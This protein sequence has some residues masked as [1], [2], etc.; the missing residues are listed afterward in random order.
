MF[1]FVTP[2]TLFHTQ[3]LE[4]QRTLPQVLDGHAAGIHDARIATRR[5]RELLP[6]VA[7]ERH[8]GA[9]DDLHA[10]FKR[11][12]RS[13]G[14]VRDAD[15]RVSLLASLERRIPHAAPT[16]V[17]VRQHRD[18][19]RLTLVRKLI[20]K[21]EHLEAFR[22]VD[23]LAAHRPNGLDALFAPARARKWRRDLQQ[24]VTARAKAANT[25]V[26]DATGVYF[27][28]RVHSARIA[29]KKLR[30]ALEIL[31]AVGQT[32]L[33][34]AIRELKKAQDTLGDLH[35]RQDLSDSL[36]DDASQANG[37]VAD[38]SGQVALVRQVLDAEVRHLHCRY[39]ERRNSI[40]TICDDMARRTTL[41]P[42]PFSR[43]VLALGALALSSGV[44]LARRSRLG[45]RRVA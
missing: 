33:S 21:L 28:N 20:K 13:L 18:H 42:V 16:L 11:V 23:S 36:A 4:L 24:L 8:V 3:L 34:A 29:I 10:R 32:D 40:V 7:E 27:P 19:E 35:D 25:A 15:V 17:V 6:L 41:A 9:T 1:D 43:P 38:S 5:I 31:H 2:S 44:Y 45:P 12:G 30:Y 26:E 39:L 37:A 14:R 22:L